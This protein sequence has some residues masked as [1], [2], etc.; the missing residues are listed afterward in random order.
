MIADALDW[1]SQH[2]AAGLLLIYWHFVIFDL[3]RY[4]LSVLTVGVMFVIRGPR[5]YRPLPPDCGVSFIMVG[6]NEGP[7]LEKAMRSIREQTHKNIQIIV[8]D[9]G[10]T[11]NMA[12]K[13]RELVARGW[14]DVFLSTG[15]RGGK[16]GGVNL[17]VPYCKHEIIL[18]GD[19]DTSYDRDAVA[20]IVWP[21]LEEP[22]CGAVAGNMAVRNQ[23]DSLCTTMQT[24]EYIHSI[25]LSRQFNDAFNIVLTA[26]GAFAA[27]RKTAVMQVGLWDVGP[28]EDNI[29]T[30]K[31]R[32][33]GWEVRFADDA[34]SMTDVPD[35]FGG[36]FR[37]RQRWNRSLIRNRVRKFR[38]IFNPFQGNF[39]LRDVIGAGGMIFY[40]IGLAVT[41]PIYLIMTFVHYGWH[42]IPI[43]IGMHLIY[44]IWDTIALLQAI[45]LFGR[46]G[47]WV[48]MLYVPIYGFYQTYYQRFVRLIAYTSEFIFR[49]SYTDSYYPQKTRASLERF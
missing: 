24:I 12:A 8:I 1:I 16:S 33:A 11:D 20:R 43:L 22:R 4:V 30:T 28:G 21:M 15:L 26:S 39:R 2:D 14:I 46:P 47:Q 34:W 35:S 19:V 3:P 27:F 36:L 42:A 48:L 38:R 5:P 10:S 44:I 37:Q 40:N 18:I 9:D 32:Q 25:T 41:F 31:L 23:D 7:G 29:I 13:G 49:M 6:H 17:A 45:L